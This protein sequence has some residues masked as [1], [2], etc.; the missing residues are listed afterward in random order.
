[1]RGEHRAVARGTY[2]HWLRRLRRW[3]HPGYPLHW[4]RRWRR[5]GYVKCVMEAPSCSRCSK[6]ACCCSCTEPPDTSKHRARREGW[7]SNPWTGESRGKVRPPWGG[8]FQ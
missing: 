4:Y 2:R 6:A 1:M 5:T 8:V 3:A 7:N